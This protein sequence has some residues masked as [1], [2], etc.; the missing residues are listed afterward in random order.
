MENKLVI[1]GEEL[2][3]EEEFLASKNTYVSNGII[4]ATVFGKVIKKDNK[5]LVEATR[6]IDKLKKNMLIIGKVT[7]SVGSAVFVKIDDIKIANEEYLALTD[8]KIIIRNKNSREKNVEK[9]C[10][11]GD[12][13]IARITDEE[14]TYIL[15]IF[16]HE[17]G[18]VYSRCHIC[19]RTM[20]ANDGFLECKFCNY[21]ETKKVSPFY[22]NINEINRFLNDKNIE[23]LNNEIKASENKEQQ[24]KYTDEKHF[25]R[26]HKFSSHEYRN[27]GEFRK[28]KPF[29][30]PRRYNNFK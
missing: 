25:D 21:K 8:G 11:L 7:D 27:K 9:P 26:H 14:D 1:P 28:P 6:S 24:N 10:G 22:M 20:S 16:E 5:I 30:R 23:I 29:N 3:I 18:V 13:V 12:I 17:T 2:G 4:R 19:G 15:D